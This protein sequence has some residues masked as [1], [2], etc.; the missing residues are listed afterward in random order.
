MKKD[1]ELITDLESLLQHM[2]L[3]IQHQK[4]REKEYQ[5]NGINCLYNHGAWF[6]L[7]I[8]ARRLE[9]ILRNNK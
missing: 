1:N 2:K 4:D 8:Y 5:E 7:E 9:D 3:M 6:T